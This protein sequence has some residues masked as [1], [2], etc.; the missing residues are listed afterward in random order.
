MYGGTQEDINAY[1]HTYSAAAGKSL[2]ELNNNSD[3]PIFDL[4]FGNGAGKL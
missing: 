4:V 1:N 3:V 2:N